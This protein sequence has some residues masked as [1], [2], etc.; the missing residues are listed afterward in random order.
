MGVKEAYFPPPRLQQAKLFSM[1]DDTYELSADELDKVERFCDFDLTETELEAFE[2]RMET[3]PAFRREVL[4]YCELHL[5]TQTTTSAPPPRFVYHRPRAEAIIG[6]AAALLLAVALAT[7]FCLSYPDEPK[8]DKPF[9]AYSEVAE[10]VDRLGLGIKRGADAAV[11]FFAEEMAAVRALDES[12]QEPQALKKL[13]ELSTRFKDKP[14]H[15]EILHWWKAMIYLETGD[16]P[17][18]KS[19]LDTIAKNKDYN[20]R[21]KAQE[22][23]HQM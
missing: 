12:G 14:R 15:A 4:L 9:Y 7:F 22:I 6:I 20:S 19:E 5:A 21:R 18:A 23:I 3:D 1:K 16:H 10:Y 8:P 11:N 13:E 17:K 2:Q